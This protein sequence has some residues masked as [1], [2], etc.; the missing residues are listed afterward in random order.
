MFKLKPIS[1]VKNVS[2]EKRRAK[3]GVFFTMPWIIGALALLV[4][5]LFYS[6]RLAFSTVTDVVSKTY[7]FAG[8]ANFKIAFENEDFLK[9]LKNTSIDA[10]VNTPLI[11]VFS[12]LIA[13]A[14]NQKFGMRAMFRTLFFLPVLLGNGYIMQQ[15]LGMNVS[16][17][18]M[19]V[20][21]GIL[22]PEELIKTLP[23]ALTAVISD[24]F[25]R[26]TIILWKSG[27]Q[28]II[29][30]AGLQGIPG[31]LYEAAYMDS[32][33]PWESFWFIT[34]PMITPM[35][36]LNA[37]YTVISAFAGSDNQILTYINDLAF[38]YTQWEYASAVSWIYFSVIILL[39]VIIFAA[40]RPFIKNVSEV[41]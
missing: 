4:Y 23:S 16:E 2:F 24:F 5:P 37:V 38:T 14:L 39:L 33:S 40:V 12:L 26:I 19:Q 21:R 28:I 8:F 9:M 6:I 31:T 20:A 34:L 10:I 7:A 32:A 29:F 41:E 27:V 22:L 11:I 35:L 13:L 3:T 18:A 15:L 17:N 25:T 36:L 30:L 1:S